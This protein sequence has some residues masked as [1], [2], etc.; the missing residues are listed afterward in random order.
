[1]KTTT[2][3]TTSA[4]NEGELDRHGSAP[5]PL[6]S[7][8][9]RVPDK[10]VVEKV[11]Q[12]CGLWNAAAKKPVLMTPAKFY[13]A[14]K[15]AMALQEEHEGFTVGDLDRFPEYWK[16]KHVAKGPLEWPINITE[17]WCRYLEWLDAQ[18]KTH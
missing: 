17:Q 11:L 4:A 8:D 18:N 6:P 3:I 5:S 16:D 1:M 9:R 12:I 2:D 7:R 15:V 14:N 13:Q 10:G